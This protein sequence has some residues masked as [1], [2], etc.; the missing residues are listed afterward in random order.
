MYADLVCSGITRDVAA[1]ASYFEFEGELLRAAV[2]ATFKR[3]R[4]VLKEVT[5]VALTSEFYNDAG[6]TQQ[7]KRFRARV[8]PTGP[9]PE[10]LR[11]TGELVREFLGPVIRAAIDSEPLTDRWTPAH[12]WGA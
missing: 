1:M 10:D 12:G 3:R 5:P 4:T 8:Q 11:E 9:A 6:R 2:A 7:W